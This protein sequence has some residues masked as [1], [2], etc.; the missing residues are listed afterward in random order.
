VLAMSP[1]VVKAKPIDANEAE[2]ARQPTGP[3]S[4]LGGGWVARQAAGRMYA[5][6]GAWP[7]RNILWKNDRFKPDLKH[8]GT[9]FVRISW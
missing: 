1:F 9:E 2:Q 8:V 6:F 5:E 7:Y 3:F 4:P